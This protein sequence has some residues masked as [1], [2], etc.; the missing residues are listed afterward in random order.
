MFFLL[1]VR[2]ARGSSSN[3]SSAACLFR[4]WFWHLLP[5]QVVGGQEPQEFRLLQIGARE[6]LD[7]KRFFNERR[8]ETGD[9]LQDGL[10]YRSCQR[11]PGDS[12]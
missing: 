6:W 1:L 12:L 8:K 5:G 2:F 4:A 10:D 3:V 11:S 9:K 7:R